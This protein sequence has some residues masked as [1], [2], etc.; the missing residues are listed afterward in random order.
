MTERRISSH[1]DTD[2]LGERGGGEGEEAHAERNRGGE[3]SMLCC[4]LCLFC[5]LFVSLSQIFGVSEFDSESWRRV[6][7]EVDKNNDGEVDFEEFQQMLLKL[8]GDN[9]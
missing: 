7:A 8:C 2:S 1:G 3:M 5:L 4:L 6:L 9:S